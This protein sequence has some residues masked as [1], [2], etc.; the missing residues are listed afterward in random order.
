MFETGMIS[1]HMSQNG[2]VLTRS[3]M[4]ALSRNFGAWARFRLRGNYIE[5]LVKTKSLLGRIFLG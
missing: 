5:I 4:F 3:L 2:T 1:D